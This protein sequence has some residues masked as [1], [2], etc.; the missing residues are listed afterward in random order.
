MFDSYTQD[1]QRIAGEKNTFWNPLPYLH[2]LANASSLRK[3]PT[4][5]HGPVPL[6]HRSDPLDRNLKATTSSGPSLDLKCCTSAHIAHTLQRLLCLSCSLCP[7]ATTPRGGPTPSPHRPSAALTL[8]K[9]REH[10]T[11]RLQ[12]WMSHHDLQKP[13]QPLA[14]MLDHIIAEPIREDLPRQRRDGHPRAL[15]LQ[16]VA[17]VFEVGVAPAHGAV[18]QLEGGDVGAADD[19]VVRVHAAGRAV[20]LGVLDLIA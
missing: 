15:P 16:D 6:F 11:A 8:H 13:L 9:T 7:S 17:E 14:P 10:L 5:V 1:L 3:P 18:L 12:Q 20:G 19:L 2:P 4:F